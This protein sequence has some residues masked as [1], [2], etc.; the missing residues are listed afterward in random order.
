MAKESVVS[1]KVKVKLKDSGT[2][3][4]DATQ[5]EGT[6]TGSGTMHMLLTAKVRAALQAGV[7]IKVEEKE[8]PKEQPTGGAGKTPATAHT[9][10]PERGGKK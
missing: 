1:V 4:H 9:K 5:E 7:L 10:T 8:V 2:I 6:V 3:F